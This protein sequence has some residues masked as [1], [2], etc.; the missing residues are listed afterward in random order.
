MFGRITKS[1]AA[2]V[3]VAFTLVLTGPQAIEG[4]D[5]GACGGSTE[6]LCVEWCGTQSE[7]NHTCVAH[8]GPGW[9]ADSCTPNVG[10]CDDSNAL[11]CHR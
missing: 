10:P 3:M 5:G 7:Q 8:C 1:A 11:I 2:V 6:V 9:H 4:R